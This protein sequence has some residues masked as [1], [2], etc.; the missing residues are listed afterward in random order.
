MSYRRI[1]PISL[2]ANS[3]KNLVLRQ[4]FAIHLLQSIKRKKYILN[5]DETWL[6]MSDFRR[7]RWQVKGRANTLKQVQV[8]PRITMIIAYD[9]T[10]QVYFS[11]LQSNSNNKT[12]ELF[13]RDLVRRLEQDR[14]SWRDDTLIV[15]DNAPYHTSTQTI[16]V[17]KKLNLPICFTGPHSYDAAPCEL[18]FAHFKNAD[19]NPNKVPMGKR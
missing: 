3:P 9:N 15:L 7:M 13:F 1:K 17:F 4:Q 18:M 5:I 19:I 6:G 11:L 14:I 2:H 16:N 10:G 12:M 8:Q